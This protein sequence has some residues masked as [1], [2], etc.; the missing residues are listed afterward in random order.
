MKQ[1]L[2][3]LAWPIDGDLGH[4]AAERPGVLYFERR[5]VLAVP[6]DILIELQRVAAPE[7]L[8]EHD[9][10]LHLALCNGHYPPVTTTVLK[11]LVATP[12]ALPSRQ[13]F[14]ASHAAAPHRVATAMPLIHAFYHFV[15]FG[16]VEYLQQSFRRSRL[17]KRVSSVGNRETCVTGKTTTN[18]Y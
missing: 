2:I 3:T 7:K 4:K 18:N 12:E 15:R 11:T 17:I 8:N 10:A 1:S 5:Q 16:F 14:A 6:S 13:T 9:W